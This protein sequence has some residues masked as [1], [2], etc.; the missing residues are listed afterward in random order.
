[1]LLQD[2]SKISPDLAQF[3]S[4]RL[5]ESE[6]FWNSISSLAEQASIPSVAK[7]QITGLA[8]TASDVTSLLG[9]AVGAP[10][11]ENA[12]IEDLAD[13]IGGWMGLPRKKGTTKQLPTAL[14]PPPAD[15]VE[16][17]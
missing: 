16:V 3:T 2:L 11:Q 14:P 6:T 10:S 15:D 7:E 4:Q 12:T 8:K 5:S 17:V 9:G 13:E 1:M